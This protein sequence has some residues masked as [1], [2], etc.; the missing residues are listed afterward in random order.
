MTM[1]E[2]MS[3]EVAAELARLSGEIESLDRGILEAG[4]VAALA[5]AKVS[6]IE[7]ALA[8]IGRLTGLDLFPESDP[9]AARRQRLQ[10]SGLHAVPGGAS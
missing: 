5:L 3:H 1:Q 8:A 9:K 2:T 6:V 10:E 7:G 4:G